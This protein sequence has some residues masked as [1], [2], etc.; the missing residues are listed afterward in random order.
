MSSIE[1]FFTLKLIRKKIFIFY[2]ITSFYYHVFLFS[3]DLIL[4]STQAKS[5]AEGKYDNTFV[6][7]VTSKIS[8]IICENSKF[9][10][11]NNYLKLN[12][13]RIKLIADIFIIY[14]YIIN[15]FRNQLMLSEIISLFR[16][17]K[18]LYQTCLH[19]FIDGQCFKLKTA[20]YII[21]RAA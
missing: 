19:S 16:L 18:S 14:Y 2:P 20:Q 3:L 4:Q 1:V 12:I 5:R 21:K 8:L 7:Y 17:N 9:K 6:L 11:Y 13:V 10:V 15:R